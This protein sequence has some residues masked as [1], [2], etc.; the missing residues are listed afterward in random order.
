MSLPERPATRVL[1]FHS[2]YGCRHRGRCCTSGWPI[3]VEPIEQARLRDAG[4]IPSG[5]PAD[6]PTLLATSEGR[7]VFHDP[8]AQGGCR[9]HR[10]LGHAALPLS[11]RQFPRQSV[12]DPRGVSVTLSHYCPTAGE[13]LEASPG[14]VHVT[15]NPPG[16]PAAA[17][18][19]GLTADH[20]LPPLLHPR[21]AMDWESW[22]TFES[23]SVSMFADAPEPLARLALAVEYTREWTVGGDS[24]I[25]HVKSAFARARGASVTPPSP[26][27]SRIAAR[28]AS[29]LAAVP[30]SWQSAASDALSTPTGRPVSD[31]VMR[32]YLAAHAFANWAAY[33]GEGLRTWYRAVDTAGCLLIHTADPGRADLILRHLADSGTLID[34]W[35]QSEPESIQD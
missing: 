17:E 31:R 24:L 6:G 7:C 5:P 9:I 32:R 30:E 19:V 33:L 4:L 13:L 29:A 23:L 2:G 28:C 35:N 12:S 26:D 11:C 3:A 10:A 22:W 15:I 27:G 18:Y 34:R 16:F 21:L 20:A 1:S 14:P 8:H 25:A